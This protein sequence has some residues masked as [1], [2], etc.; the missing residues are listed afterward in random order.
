MAATGLFLGIVDVLL[1]ACGYVWPVYRISLL[2]SSISGCNV[3]DLQDNS[4]DD[5]QQM[6]VFVTISLLIITT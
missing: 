5:H 6:H 2:M 3:K 4:D 1:G